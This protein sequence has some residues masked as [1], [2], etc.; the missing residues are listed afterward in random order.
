MSEHR[1]RREPVAQKQTKLTIVVDHDAEIEVD[2]DKHGNVTIR[3][4]RRYP[5]RCTSKQADRTGETAKKKLEKSL[6]PTGE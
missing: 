1:A 6:K 3:F 2:R 4:E 5:Q